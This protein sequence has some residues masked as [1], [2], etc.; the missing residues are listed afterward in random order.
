MQLIIQKRIRKLKQKLGTN[1]FNR[2]AKQR[3]AVHISAANA[4]MSEAMNE[5]Q[6]L[7]G[8]TE[9]EIRQK[10][11]QAI[12]ELR[13]PPGARLTE[14]VLADAF[15]VSRT[16]IRLV[17]AR[18]TQDGVLVKRPNGATCVASPTRA[19]IGQILRVRRMVEPEI[20]SDLA[21]SYKALSFASIVEHLKKEELARTSGSY[22]DLVRLTGEFHLHLAELSGNRFLSNLIYQLQALVCLGVVMYT[23]ADI[24]CPED[25]HQQIADSIM[26]GD[27]KSAA[28]LMIHHLDHVEENI[29]SSSKQHIHFNET[30]KW[31]SG[32]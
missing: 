14:S 2:L 31:L 32:K 17:I 23:N 20:A 28:K 7:R 4:W 22:G 10:L 27:D 11:L 9:R 25:E 26:K 24:A 6:N 12:F 5:D 8:K 29:L 16:V 13:M 3:S 15:D 19:E 1:S 18:M 21:R 30:L